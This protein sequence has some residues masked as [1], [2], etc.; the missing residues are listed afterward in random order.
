MQQGVGELV[1][2]SLEGA[3]RLAELVALLGV[4]GG[5]LYGAGGEAEELG[6]RAQRGPVISQISVGFEGGSALEPAGYQ[7]DRSRCIDRL[8]RLQRH[9]FSPHRIERAVSFDNDDVGHIGMGYESR[10]NGG[11]NDTVQRS[12]RDQ[13]SFDQ[14]FRQSCSPCFFED[15]HQ[16]DLGHAAREHVDHAHLAELRPPFGRESRA[17]GLGRTFLLQQLAHRAREQ[18]LV[19]GRLESHDRGKPSTRSA[20]MLRWISFVPA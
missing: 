7:K 5:H 13:R 15:R 10:S 1:L 16:V 9:R 3:D 18:L 11:C 4:V 19:G 6:G 14:V 17:R 20:T 12:S 2:H 8:D